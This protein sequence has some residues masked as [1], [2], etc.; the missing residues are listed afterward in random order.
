MA[1][2]NAKPIRP[3]NKPRIYYH[4]YEVGRAVPGY[5]RVRP[6]EAKWS[7]LRVKEREARLKANQWCNRQN[8][9]EFILS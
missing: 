8:Q 1:R 7:Q 2:S 9:K 6:I 3:Q 4:V 5:W